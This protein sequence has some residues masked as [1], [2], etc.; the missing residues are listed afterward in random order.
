MYV[1]TIH[2][3]QIFLWTKQKR[4]SN[5]MKN[6]FSKHHIYYLLV[7]ALSYFPSFSFGVQKH[8]PNNCKILL[9]LVDSFCWTG[10]Q[11]YGPFFGLYGTGQLV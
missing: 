6:D 1:T 4:C 2:A 3:L 11:S 9:Q 10:L 7:T 5:I 8:R